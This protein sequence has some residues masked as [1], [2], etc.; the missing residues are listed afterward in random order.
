MAAY[1]SYFSSLPQSPW[2]GQTCILLSSPRWLLLFLLSLR[3]LQ[4][5]LLQQHCCCYVLPLPPIL[6]SVWTF[7]LPLWQFHLNVP[8][9]PQIRCPK[10]ICAPNVFF[11]SSH[12]T[13]HRVPTTGTLQSCSSPHLPTPVLKRNWGPSILPL[14]LDCFLL[15]IPTVT[16]QARPLPSS[17]W[18]T[19]KSFSL[20][21]PLPTLHLFNP[22]SMLSHLWN[23]PKPPGAAHPSSHEV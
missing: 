5:T 22:F 16:I 23:M 18:I 7:W 19:A 21:F 1:S 2:E 9:G 11:L 8:K 20:G 10:G 3:F 6:V 17:S 13:I 14:S 4:S 15:S 12:T